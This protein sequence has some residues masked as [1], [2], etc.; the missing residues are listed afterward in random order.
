MICF[1][2]K[3]TSENWLTYFFNVIIFLTVIA[4]SN[5]TISVKH[6]YIIKHFLQNKFFLNDDICLLRCCHIYDQLVCFDVVLFLSAVFDMQH[7][8]YSVNSE[9]L[10]VYFCNH[11]F[12]IFLRE[13]ISCHVLDHDHEA[14]SDDS[15]LWIESCC[16][17]DFLDQMM[18]DFY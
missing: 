18:F 16:L 8:H 11:S 12:L 15:D 17:T 9:V 7:L 5:E 2:L 1:D 10:S 14:S 3:F 4:M 13:C 6:F